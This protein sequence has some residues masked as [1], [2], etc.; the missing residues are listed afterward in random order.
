MS[1]EIT[2]DR[3]PR[4]PSSTLEG[5]IEA[6]RKLHSKARTASVKPGVAV[7][8]LGY[9]GM[10]GT[11]MS[12]LATLGQYGLIE[13]SS[14]NIAVSPLA[15]RILHPSGDTQKEAAIREAALLPKVFQE[16]LIGFEHCAVEVIA[17]HLIQGGFAPDKAKKVAQVYLDNRSFA[18]LDDPDKIE[19]NESEERSNPS[20]KNAQ[21][22][23]RP[24]PP[25]LPPVTPPA[26]DPA[27]LL[28]SDNSKMLAQYSIP[29]GENQATLVFTGRELTVEDFEALA[30]FVDFAK[31]QFARKAKTKTATSAIKRY[32]QVRHARLLDDFGDV[33]NIVSEEVREGVTFYKS[34]EGDLIPETKL[35]FED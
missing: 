2:K 10:T 30:D 16:A 1:E 32:P 5:A 22:D 14:G 15:V 31:R 35:E 18:K 21:P 27:R 7:Q 4:A 33:L 23:L 29:L 25:S 19:N 20:S 13:R 12:M 6:V 24:L 8:A 3:S 11:S 9:A 28:P 34:D 17:N 26:P